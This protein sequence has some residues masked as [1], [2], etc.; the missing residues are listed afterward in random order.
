MKS[1]QQWTKSVF[2]PL[3]WLDGGVNA[4]QRSFLYWDDSSKAS[5][6]LAIKLTN[7]RLLALLRTSSLQQQSQT[8]ITPLYYC[9]K[10]TRT[11]RRGTITRAGTIIH[12]KHEPREQWIRHLCG[13]KK[14]SFLLLQ[15]FIVFYL[16][17]VYSMFIF[18]LS[19]FWHAGLR[20]KKLIQRG[21]H[22]VFLGG[23]R[24]CTESDLCR[25]NQTKTFFK[26]QTKIRIWKRIKLTEAKKKKKRHLKSQTYNVQTNYLCK[27]SYIR[28]N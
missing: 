7:K 1:K 11:M 26:Y 14:S 12:I 21:R 6:L 28:T 18:L 22:F 3:F 19:Y 4:V 2:F 24:T 17:A 20:A 13:K 27:L 9:C 5:P 25:W 23:Y 15:L 10:S 8:H 16:P